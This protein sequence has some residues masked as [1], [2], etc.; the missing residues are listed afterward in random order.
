MHICQI[1]KT[2]ADFKSVLDKIVHRSGGHGMEN[3]GTNEKIY[4][5]VPCWRCFGSV[6]MRVRACL[7]RLCV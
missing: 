4:F 3:I 2:F 6:C 5:A 7:A 1:E